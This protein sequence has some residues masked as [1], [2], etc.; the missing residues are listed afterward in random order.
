MSKLCGKKLYKER[1]YGEEESCQSFHRESI[2]YVSLKIL[3]EFYLG[4]N[5]LA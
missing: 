4:G 1:V 3:Q 5:E 2:L